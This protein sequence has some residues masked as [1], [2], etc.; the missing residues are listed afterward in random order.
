MKL[1]EWGKDIFREASNI[2]IS[3]GL[4]SLSQMLGG[5]IEIEV[6]EVY[7]IKRAEFLKTLAE[8]GISKSFVVMFNITEGLKGLAI[9]QFPQA[10]ATALAAALM[11]LDPSQIKELDE[12]SKSAIMEVGN[13]LVSVYTDILSTLIGESVSLTPPI[14]ASTLYDVEKELASGELKDIEDIVMFK[15]KFK[16]TEL[17]IESYFCL[18]PT[19]D[20]LEKIISRLEKEVKEG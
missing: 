18:V 16:K 20:S 9:L 13:I 6:P 1:S 2:A 12:M 5:P 8:N 7:M 10:S 19:Q 3:H 4:T 14:P 15:N 17:G 11:G